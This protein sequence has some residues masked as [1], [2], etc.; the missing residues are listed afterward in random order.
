LSY[1]TFAYSDLRV[2]RSADAGVTVT[3]SVHNTSKRGGDAVVQVYLGA[4]GGPMGQP[5]G[6]MGQPGGPMGQ[7]NPVPAGLAFPVRTLASF[8]RIWIEAGGVRQLRLQVP[9]ERLRYWSVADNA[10]RDASEG[11]TVYVGA[12]SRDLPLSAPIPTSQNLT[13]NT[14]R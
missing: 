4:P 12:S 5:G 10:W 2:A 9:P 3:C 8:E 13:R 14:A 11:R 1:S 7:P 6:P